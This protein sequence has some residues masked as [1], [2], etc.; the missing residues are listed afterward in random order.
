MPNSF[1]PDE[2]TP[3]NREEGVPAIL[4][5]A[6]EDQALNSV[7]QVG[8]ARLAASGILRPFKVRNFNLLFSGQIV[9]VIGDALYAVALPWLILNNGGNAQEL[10][11]V[12][13]A[14]GIPRAGCGLVGGWL[15]DRL[16]PRRLM[17]IADAIRALLVATL[18]VLALWG[19][20]TIFQL[21]AIAVPLGA[22][23]GAFMPASMSI[24]PDILSDE[25][26]QAGNALNLSSMQGAYMVGSALAGVV[27]SAF[28][29]GAG[30]AIDAA[31]FVVSA[32]SLA[33]MRT[34]SIVTHSKSAEKTDNE[35]PSFS[36]GEQEVQ[37]SF[38]HF[39]F[40]S[41]LIQVIL[42][43][44]LVAGFCWGGLLEVALPTLVHGPMHGDASAY[45]AI[46]AVA[47]AGALTGSIFAGT[48][49]KLKHKGLIILLDGLIMAASMALIPYAGIPGAM[50]WMLICGAANS[51]T[52]VQLFTV[53]HLT[54]P[55]HLLGRIM[56]LLTFCSFSMYPISAALA[57]VLSNRF[58]PA[59]LFPFS[60]L[61][62][63]LVM[64]FAMTQK[65]L[66]DL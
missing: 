16:R 23:G 61:L 65:A 12:L 50:V 55:R 41:R 51:I 17:L 9:S 33:L 11:I 45:G 25:A 32:L 34:A 57:G 49:G 22:L 52:N 54:L 15:S 44:A 43:I 35:S 36:P 13:A 7:A 46:L 59:I 37:V 60:G 47:C 2:L 30:L 4:P 26:L 6:D 3:T 8:A 28:T 14:Y 1:N 62:L 27:V 10:G 58:G 24:L 64:L 18:A 53:V 42:L 40:T 63:G 20:P 5:Q 38:W 66:R 56:G 19:H 39:L 29:A 31:S 48:L 21:C